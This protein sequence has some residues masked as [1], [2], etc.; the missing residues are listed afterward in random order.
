MQSI[1]QERLKI[2]IANQYPT[3]LC[4][5]RKYAGYQEAEDL[6]QEAIMKAYYHLES[7]D[8][9]N[10]LGWLRTIVKNT[11]L[12]QIEKNR[13]ECY[14]DEPPVSALSYNEGERNIFEAEYFSRADKLDEAVKSVGE[15]MLQGL[16]QKQIAEKL[17]LP[18][19]RVARQTT[20]IRVMLDLPNTNWKR[21]KRVNK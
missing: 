5:A 15:L 2:E 8:G 18:L 19:G 20:D 16:T 11:Y 1:I 13:K 3:I 17:N 10:L 9:A 14:C 12:K 21:R 7:F 4:F 6:A